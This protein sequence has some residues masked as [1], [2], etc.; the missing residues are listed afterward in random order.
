MGWGGWDENHDGALPLSLITSLSLPLSSPFLLP[1]PS[2]YS[3]RPP[4]SLYL[5]PSL[6][7]PSLH[8]SLPTSLPP[9]PSLL[10]P[11]SFSAASNGSPDEP[12]WQKASCLVSTVP[13][14]VGPGQERSL[15]PNKERSAPPGC[16]EC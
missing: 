3:S 1:R 11:P 6:L 4:F 7:H 12:D 15:E 13:T 9:S 8:L 5:S 10:P 2:L 16:T 14:D